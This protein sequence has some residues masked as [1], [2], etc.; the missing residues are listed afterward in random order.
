MPRYTAT[1]RTPLSFKEAFAYMED[2]HN[3]VE[4]DPGVTEVTQTRGKG[5]GPDAVYDVTVD[6]SGREMTFEYETTEY[7]PP[8]QIT[9]YGK[10][11][12]FRSTDVITVQP[13]GADGSLVTYDAKLEMVFPLSLA[14]AL[15]KGTFQKIGDKAVAGLT[16]ELNGTR[17]S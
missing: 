6:N 7:R 15:L 4:W 14:D 16:R 8:Q 5:P 9:V 3:F 13:D 2:L 1:V 17:V 11:G 12:I 10:S